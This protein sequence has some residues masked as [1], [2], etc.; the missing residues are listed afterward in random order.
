MTP[1]R[2]THPVGTNLSSYFESI[3]TDIPKKC[4]GGRPVLIQSGERRGKLPPHH[5]DGGTQHECCIAV[6]LDWMH[7]HFPLQMMHGVLTGK[8]IEATLKQISEH[9][10]LTQQSNP[11]SPQAVHRTEAAEDKRRHQSGSRQTRAVPA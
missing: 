9:R 1:V 8:E 2:I 11:L 7:E 4:C 10:K 5:L 6:G 3:A